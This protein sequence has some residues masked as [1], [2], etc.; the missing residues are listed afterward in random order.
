MQY[1]PRY[2][3]HPM[4]SSTAIRRQYRGR[5]LSDRCQQLADPMFVEGMDIIGRETENGN[6]VAVYLS[7]VKQRETKYSDAFSLW[8]FPALNSLQKFQRKRTGEEITSIVINHRWG[9]IPDI[10]EEKF[11]K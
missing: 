11:K 1:Q 2:R 5:K 6:A 4:K 3:I 8:Q 9:T 10:A 7:K